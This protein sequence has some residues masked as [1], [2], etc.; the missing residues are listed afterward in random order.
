MA[1]YCQWISAAGSYNNLFNKFFQFNQKSIAQVKQKTLKKN[2]GSV[3][4]IPNYSLDGYEVLRVVKSK[5]I[6]VNSQV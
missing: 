3:P 1:T 5:R 4:I 6:N 2:M